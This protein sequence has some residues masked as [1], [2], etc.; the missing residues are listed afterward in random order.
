MTVTGSSGGRCQCNAGF[1]ERDRIYGNLG[2]HDASFLSQLYFLHRVV[3][4]VGIESSKM[5]ILYLLIPIVYLHGFFLC[6]DYEN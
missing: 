6:G 4:V 5:I 2:E 1:Q 3:I